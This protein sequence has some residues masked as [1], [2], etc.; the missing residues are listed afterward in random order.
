VASRLGKATP[1][2]PFVLGCGVGWQV[3][4]DSLTLHFYVHLLLKYYTYSL[5]FKDFRTLLDGI[6]GTRTGST[7]SVYI[8]LTFKNHLINYYS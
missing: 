5:K 2:P 4:S 1:I 8:M 7:A 3:M 6:F